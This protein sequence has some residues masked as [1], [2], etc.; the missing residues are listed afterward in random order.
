MSKRQL[1]PACK[2][3]PHNPGVW[4]PLV[5]TPFKDRGGGGAELGPLFLICPPCTSPLYM[6]TLSISFSLHTLNALG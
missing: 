4:R 6:D 5:A 1:P 3:L 2:N